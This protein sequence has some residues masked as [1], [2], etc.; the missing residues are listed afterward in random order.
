MGKKTYKFTRKFDG[1]IFKLDTSFPRRDR[2]EGYA[3]AKRA[4]GY[5]ARVVFYKPDG[6][7]EIW[8]RKK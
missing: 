2:A 8:V 3:D 7:Y 6:W 5:Y 4:R 1:R